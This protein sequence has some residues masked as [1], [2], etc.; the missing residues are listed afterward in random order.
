MSDAWMKENTGSD[1]VAC[2][3]YVTVERHEDGLKRARSQAHEDATKGLWVLEDK[4][5]NFHSNIMGWTI[6]SISAHLIS[7]SAIITLAVTR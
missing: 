2:D 4:V 6:V 5:S 7:F 3:K 1:N